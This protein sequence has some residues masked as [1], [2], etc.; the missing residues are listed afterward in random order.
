MLTR[1]PL[2]ILIVI[3]IITLSGMSVLAADNQTPQV[4]V[5]DMQHRWAVANYV[6]SEKE[7][8]SAFIELLSSVDTYQQAYSDSAAV[9]IWG[10]IIKST[11]AGVKGGLGALKY[12]KASKADLEK[13]IQMDDQALSG[14]AYTSLGTLYFK[15][16]GWPIG[17]G[18][19]SKADELLKQ[20]LVL[21]PNGIDSNYFYGEFLYEQHHYAQAKLHLLKAQ[22]AKP[23]A[24]RPI[25]DAGRQREILMLLTKVEKHLP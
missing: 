1:N 14:S 9:W 17:F 15:V 12:A 11:Y 22:D 24:K 23:R 3:L 10:A 8:N 13:A 2:C 19:K 5:A 16:P 4:A 21:S 18:N 20:A 6:L 25:A 7:K